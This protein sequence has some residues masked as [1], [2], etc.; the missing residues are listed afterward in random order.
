MKLFGYLD[1]MII[2][3]N[4]NLI[5]F[6]DWLGIFQYVVF[7]FMALFILWLI[8]WIINAFFPRGDP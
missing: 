5:K 6:A 2:F 7:P 3:I 4:D 8:C 1:D